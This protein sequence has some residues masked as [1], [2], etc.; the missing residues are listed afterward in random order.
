MSQ[1]F[2]PLFTNLF[3]ANLIAIACIIYILIKRAKRRKQDL[4]KT[5]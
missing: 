4:H 2:T 3:I 1:I 5:E